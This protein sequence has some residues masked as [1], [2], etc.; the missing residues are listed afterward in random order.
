MQTP[1]GGCRGEQVRAARPPTG[2]MLMETG[3][4]LLIVSQNFVFLKKTSLEGSRQ[5][6]FMAKADL[7][8]GKRLQEEKAIQKSGQQPMPIPP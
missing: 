2:S 1:S 5:H 7:F 4:P 8:F 6:H 3:Q